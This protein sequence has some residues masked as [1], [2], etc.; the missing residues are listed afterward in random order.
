MRISQRAFQV[1]DVRLMNSF[2]A[3]TLDQLD[4]TAKPG[5]HIGRERFEFLSNAIVEQFDNPSHQPYYCIFAM[6]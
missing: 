5:L 1:L 4:E 3:V 6:S 2:E